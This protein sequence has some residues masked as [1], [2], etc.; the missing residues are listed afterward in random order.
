MEGTVTSLSNQTITIHTNN[1]YTY[2]F[3][4]N[5]DIKEKDIINKK[6]KFDPI[7]KTIY[8]QQY[9]TLYLDNLIL[10]G[11]Y[12]VSYKVDLFTIPINKER[13]D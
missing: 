2:I 13:N 4:I 3:N 9:R 1:N 6:I 7:D 5:S 8:T 12:L 11:T 10:K